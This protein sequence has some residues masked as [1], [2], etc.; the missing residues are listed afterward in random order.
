MIIGLAAHV[1]G[2]CAR[3]CARYLR[4]GGGSE[5]NYERARGRCMDAAAASLGAHR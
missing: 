4:A 1:I 3:V 2:R 5:F